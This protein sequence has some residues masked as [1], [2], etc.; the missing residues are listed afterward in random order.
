MRSVFE[1]L[2]RLILRVFFREVEIV[3][4]ENVPAEAPVVFVSNHPNALI[5][6]VFLLCRSPR[7]VV[8]LAKEP[9]FRTPGVGWLVK[10]FGSLPVYR[11]QDGA[12]PKDNA[13]TIAACRDALQRGQAIALFPEGTTH[14]DPGL[15]PL[16]SGAARIAISANSSGDHRG[17]IRIVPAGLYYSAKRTFRSEASLVY[18]APLEVPVVDLDDNHEP[19]RDVAHALTAQIDGALRTVTVQ[20]NNLDALAIARVAERIFAAAE[21][22]DGESAGPEGSEADGPGAIFEEMN[23]RQRLV[24]GYEALAEAHPEELA[25]AVTRVGAYESQIARHRLSHRYPSELTARAVAAEALRAFL[26]LLA[27]APLAIPGALVNYLPYRLVDA[28]S[29]RTSSG[30]EVVATMKVLGAMLI[31]PLT[32]LAVAGAILYWVG[33][34][35]ALGALVLDPIAA[36][37]ALVAAER[38]GELVQG[39]RFVWLGIFRPRQKDLLVAERKEIRDLILHLADLLPAP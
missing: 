10:A 8:F 35:L 15:K 29:R 38:L 11:K 34:L 19:P 4:E 1:G 18:G 12:D 13:R 21:R 3:G 24:D 37:V 27:L 9:L 5:D 14:S 16:K 25:A 23:L 33:P 36:F 7:E 30:E 17:E 6:P 28:V 2:F 26:A 20:A 39:T 32:W 31:F 22:D